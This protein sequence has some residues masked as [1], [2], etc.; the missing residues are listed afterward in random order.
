MKKP[1][2]LTQAEIDQATAALDRVL[3]YFKDD[4]RIGIRLASISGQHSGRPLIEIRAVR[5][6]PGPPRVTTWGW[7]AP[8]IREHKAQRLAEWET[9]D[10]DR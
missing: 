4:S 9:I 6:E 8:F 1:P 5:V 3:D 7:A 2:Q 10:N